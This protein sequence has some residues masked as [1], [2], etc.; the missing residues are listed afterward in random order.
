MR[1][2][3]DDQQD[4][5]AGLNVEPVVR[6]LLDRPVGGSNAEAGRLGA[7]RRYAARR[8]DG[9]GWADIAQRQIERERRAHAGRA[10]KMDFAAQQVRQF[11]ADG[12]TE[13]GTAVL[14]AGAGV[15]LL[16][17]LEDDLLLFQRNADARIGD[18]EG[19]HGGRLI[20]H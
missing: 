20:E 12:E 3:L 18:L 13:A 10:A 4:S 8:P 14:A 19:H 2:V 5:V 9:G 7:W 1:V 11:A 15:R 17:R 16:K 6:N